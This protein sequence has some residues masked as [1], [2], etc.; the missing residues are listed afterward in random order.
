MMLFH[1]LKC[2]YFL[3]LLTRLLQ[4]HWA[5]RG[6]TGQFGKCLYFYQTV[7]PETSSFTNTDN[8]KKTLCSLSSLM[9]LQ[10]I[11]SCR[12]LA[13][14]LTHNATLPRQLRGFGSK[15]GPKLP[16]WRGGEEFLTS[17][18]VCLLIQARHHQ[19]DTRDP[20]L[21]SHRAQHN[22][23]FH[24]VHVTPNTLLTLR[25]SFQ[26][27]PLQREIVRPNVENFFNCIRCCR[28]KL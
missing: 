1:R 26:R 6:E 12:N 24:L 21:S 4:K 11:P 13:T 28:K 27:G 22:I 14:F 16:H 9:V 20:T 7:G 25:R 5:G 15:C 3:N 10:T 17:E 8:K 23:S 2:F 18:D 19:P